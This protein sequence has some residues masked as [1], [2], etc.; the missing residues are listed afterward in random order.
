MEV[1]GWVLDTDKLTIS[2]PSRKSSKLRQV[3]EDWPHSRH[4]ATCKNIAELTG[5][6][7][8]VSVSV[9]SEKCF[10]QKLLAYANMPL[11]LA[12]VF[13][14]SSERSRWLIPLG[15]EFHDDLE[16]WRWIVEEGM[17]TSEGGLSAPMCRLVARPP[18][19]HLIS[20]AFTHAVGG[21]CLETGQYWR[22]NL[23]EKTLARFRGSIKH[24]QSQDSSSI[25]TI[26]LL[27]MMMSA[28][29]LVVVCGERPVGDKDCVL[30]R[31][32][33]EAA[34]GCGVVGGVRSLDR[35]LS[36]A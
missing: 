8:H 25:N 7:L 35:R 11:S 21:F 18:C 32:D 36:C 31:G 10:V 34:A 12:A 2:L 22:Y 24:L 9:R 5:F 3:L 19:H 4:F 17:G 23:S 13:F 33:N 20:D 6:L 1:L 30:L 28:Y 27:G 16:V 29:M 15:S 14:T 26:E